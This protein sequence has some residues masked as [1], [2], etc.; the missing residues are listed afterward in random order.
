MSN[1]AIQVRGLSKRYRIGE[2]QARYRTLRE[3]LVEALALSVAEGVQAPFSRL[4]SVVRSQSS[5][6]SDQTIWAL[7][8]PVLSLPKDVSFEAAAISRTSQNRMT[9]I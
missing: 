2:P 4:S 6:V 9:W 7:K 8:G 1:I 5:A 3:S